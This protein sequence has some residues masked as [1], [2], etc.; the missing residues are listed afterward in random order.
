[1]QNIVSVIDSRPKG[2]LIPC[3]SCIPLFIEDRNV[4]YTDDFFQEWIGLSSHITI[5]DPS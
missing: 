5:T 2:P 3:P 4:T 1:M